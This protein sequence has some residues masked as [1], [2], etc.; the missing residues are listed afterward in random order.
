MMILEQAMWEVVW[1][2]VCT[3]VR[4]LCF[5]AKNRTSFLVNINVN[6]TL[7]ANKLILDNYILQKKKKFTG[8]K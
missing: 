2:S 6:F 3:G 4:I 8:R 5:T 1:V 7:T